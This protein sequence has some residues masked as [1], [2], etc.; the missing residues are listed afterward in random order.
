MIDFSII[1]PV[2]NASL[3]LEFAI[4]SVFKQKKKDWELV[5]VNDASTDHSLEIIQN[6]AAVDSR[7]KIIDLPQN[8]GQG[9]A[10]N[11]AIKK[12]KGTYLVF[13]DADDLGFNYRITNPLLYDFIKKIRSFSS[14]VIFFSVKQVKWLIPMHLNPTQKRLDLCL[15]NRLEM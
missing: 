11:L 10:R 5:A 15:I 4:E 6:Y 3:Y 12:A 8:R 13:L 7:I 1:I 2:F 9:Y 14:L